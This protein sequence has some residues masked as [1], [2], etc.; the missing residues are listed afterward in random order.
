M[1]AKH[2]LFPCLL[3][4]VLFSSCTQLDEKISPAGILMAGTAVE[5]RIDMSYSY[6][7]HHYDDCVVLI[8]NNDYSF[9]VGADSHITTDSGRMDEMLDIGLRDDDLFY[10]HLGDIADTKASYYITLDSLLQEAKQRYVAKHYRQI[11]PYRY[12]LNINHEE[13]PL[14]STY[15]EITFPFFPVVGN[16]DITRNGWALWSSIFHSSFY[17]IDVVVLLEDGDFAF[18]HLIFLD[19]ASGTL[20][21]RQIELIEQGILNGKYLADGGYRN[22]FVFSHTNIFRPQFNEFAS[23]FPREETFYLLD[24]F[25][26]WNVSYVFCGHVHTWDDR[27]YNGVHYLTLNAMSER[28]NPEPGDYLVRVNVSG[29]GNINWESVRMNYTPKH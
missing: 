15:D 12:V 22:T 6:F 27:D 21:K 23:T 2:I 5:D 13:N 3:A 25:E 11:D 10:A 29:D 26:K 20:G 4:A 16:H 8:A 17:E 14:T 19:S 9:L 7:L 28:N 24:K 18:D 1:K